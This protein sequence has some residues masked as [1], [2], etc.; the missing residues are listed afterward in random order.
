MTNEE[1]LAEIKKQEKKYL[2]DNFTHLDAWNLGSFIV[3]EIY[4]LNLPLAICIR[5][6]ADDAILFQ[7]LT[8]ETNAMH[9]I[10]MYK[11][12]NTV[13]KTQHSSY[14]EYILS[15]ISKGM[16]DQELFDKNKYMIKGGGFP[17][18]NK[19]GQLYAI[20]TVSNLDHPDDHKFII[21]CLDKLFT[22]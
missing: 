6:V 7:H 9:E 2:F 17:I 8:N 12:Y 13:K 20:L 4:R 19:N 15:L 14:Y 1:L 22:Q 11:K 21:S 5:D 16:M 10:Y 18:K 3:E